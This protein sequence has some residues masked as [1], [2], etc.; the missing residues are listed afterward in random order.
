MLENRLLR[1]LEN[2]VQ[3]VLE[4]R[5][6]RVLE[7]RVL[8]KLCSPKRDEVTR[9]WKRLHSESLVTC[10]HYCIVTACDM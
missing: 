8:S 10:G 9:E 7:N 5:V 1:V 2:R 4:N 6:L 3:S